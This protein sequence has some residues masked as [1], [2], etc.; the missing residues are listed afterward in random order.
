MLLLVHH[1]EAEAPDVD[2][3]RPLTARGRAQAELVA[4]DLASRGFAPEVI[5]HSG[6]LRGRQTAEACWRVC[7]PLATLSAV[8]GLLP[9]DPPEWMR[10]RVAGD[11][12]GILIVGHMPHLPALLGLLTGNGGATFPPHGAVALETDGTRWAERWRVELPVEA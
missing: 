12:R 1:A 6:K 9:G 5:W 8:R 3:M 11:V 2:A 10:D 7:N 4:R